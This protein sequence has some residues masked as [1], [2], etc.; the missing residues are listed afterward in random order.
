MAQVLV[1]VSC[2][3]NCVVIGCDSHSYDLHYCLSSL[4]RYIAATRSFGQAA[5]PL[6]FGFT[7]T[8]FG[9]APT[10]QD[11]SEQ[12]DKPTDGK[13][14]AAT[15]SV[16]SFDDLEHMDDS[17]EDASSGDDEDDRK[18]TSTVNTDCTVCGPGIKATG[19]HFGALTCEACKAFFRR[20]VRKDVKH[21]CRLDRACE[22]NKDTRN[23]C[24]YCRYQKC[25]RMGMKR[26]GKSVSI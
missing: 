23:Q 10:P 4:S 26:V 11:K 8:V 19:Y 16:A 25:I 1:F 18:P 22:I 7:Q 13:A 14:D 21:S 12:K 3:V 17:S 5:P 20:T 9:A 24:P 2:K 15:A 6:C